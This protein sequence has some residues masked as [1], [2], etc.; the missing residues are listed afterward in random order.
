M[1][2]LALLEG[3]SG[4]P[5]FGTLRDAK[6]WIECHAKPRTSSHVYRVTNTGQTLIAVHGKSPDGS[7]RWNR[8]NR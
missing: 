3:A 4:G 6:R 8:V 7:I 2:Y 1:K 5:V